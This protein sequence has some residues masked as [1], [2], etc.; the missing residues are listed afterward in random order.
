MQGGENCD[1]ATVEGDTQ[2]NCTAG[3]LSDDF[4]LLSC[5]HYITYSLAH[6]RSFWLNFSIARFV[7]RFIV[8]NP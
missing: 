4:R 8:A 2:T 7:F 5:I 6:S 1:A 3:K